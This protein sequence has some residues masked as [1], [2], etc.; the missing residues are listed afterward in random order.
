MKCKSCEE[1]FSE[2]WGG[3]SRDEEAAAYKDDATKATLDPSDV[4]GNAMADDMLND[5]ERK[6]WAAWDKRDRSLSENTPDNF[7]PE[8][9]EPNQTS[10]SSCSN[11]TQPHAVLQENRAEAQTQLLR[12]AELAMEQFGAQPVARNRILSAGSSTCQGPKP[13]E[14]SETPISKLSET[15]FF[16]QR[17]VLKKFSTSLKNE[18]LE[19]LKLSSWH[20]WQVRYLTVSRE[21]TQ[22]HADQAVVGQCP[23]AI[24]WPK[25]IAKKNDCSVT[26][27]KDNGRGGVL[28]DD[29]KQVRPTV[30]NEFYEKHLPRKLKKAF[31]EY[32]GVVLDFAHDGGIRQVHFCFKTAL[33]S[34]AF[35][36]AMLIIK[37]AAE[38]SRQSMASG[39]IESYPTVSSGT[40]SYDS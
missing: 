1:K 10:D 14:A 6:I 15:L 33:D 24:L 30:S 38:R 35:V 25:R 22:L 11:A 36:T 16:E 5:V 23:K 34:Q 9:V 31:P 20:K 29:L 28:F 7:Q 40:K 12:H 2:A 21:V 39:K 3:L 26:N 32:A 13:L 19:V 27:I 17:A 37:E 18:G 8:N 4:M